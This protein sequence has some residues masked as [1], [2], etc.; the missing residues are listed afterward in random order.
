MSKKVWFVLVLA[1]LSGAL[2]F[3]FFDFNP[4][5]MMYSVVADPLGS[6]NDFSTTIVQYWQPIATGLGGIMGTLGLVSRAYTRN[7]E[8]AQRIQQS[9]QNKILQDEKLQ[10]SLEAERDRAEQTVTAQ[11]KQM[12]ELQN[13]LAEYKRQ[14]DAKQLEVDRANE[15][16]NEAERLF[17]K[18]Y[19]PEPEKP[20][21]H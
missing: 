18:K 8:Q 12:K 2:L 5:A 19:F 6:I 9:L 7:K 14:V 4:V 15:R 17:N 3:L 11:S 10:A 13:Q 1:F 16:A 20:T 21:V